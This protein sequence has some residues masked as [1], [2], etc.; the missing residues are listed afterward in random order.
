MSSARKSSSFGTPAS[1]IEIDVSIVSNLLAEQHPDLAHLPLQ[2]VDAGWDNVMF[3]L[4]D[5]WSVRLPRRQMAA[6]L[7]K[8]EQIWLPQLPKLPISIPTPYR[9]GQPALDYPWCWSILPWLPGATADQQ[10]PDANQA[11]R[12]AAFLRSLHI[13]APSNA[14]CNPFRGV[15]L[16]HRAAAVAER[17]QQLERKTNLITPAVKRIWN[18]ALNAPIDVEPTWLHGDL[19]ARNILVERGLIT[20]IIDWGDLTAGDR[21]TDLAAIWMLFSSQN[22][23]QQAIAEYAIASEATLQRAKGWAVMFGVLLLDTGLVDN[24]RHAVMGERTLQR[25]VED[26]FV[27]LDSM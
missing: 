19:H 20:G 27:S 7:I 22:A 11:Q 1:E 14:P 4:G 15:P 18:Q 8:N 2:R 12:F 5:Q 16:Q 25:V 23:R 21:A 24:P 17:I 9:I 6:T 13:P 26:E 10:E 3:R